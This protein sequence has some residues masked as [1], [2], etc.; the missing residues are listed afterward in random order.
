MFAHF[1]V[2]KII[3]ILNIIPRCATVHCSACIMKGLCSV[4]FWWNTLIVL[5]PNS[6]K[7]VIIKSNK[8]S[9]FWISFKPKILMKQFYRLPL[10]TVPLSPPPMV[11]YGRV[12][13]YFHFV[14]SL[15]VNDPFRSFFHRLKNISYILK[16]IVYFPSIQL[17]FSLDI[18]S[19]KSFVQWNRSFSRKR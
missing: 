18:H 11:K 14:R 3:I 19:N 17:V 8:V 7:T 5:I 16:I 6:K 2:N 15:F 10:F 12:R 1:V 9:L 4:I 13:L